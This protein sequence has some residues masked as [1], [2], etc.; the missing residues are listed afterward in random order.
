MQQSKYYNQHAH[1]L[2]TLAEGN[3]VRMKSF[4]LGSNVW[5]KGTVTSRLDGRSYMVETPDGETL[6]EELIPP[7][8]KERGWE[9]LVS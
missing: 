2:P 8:E 3:V 1:D 9:R 4:Q 7:A 5:K 6:Q